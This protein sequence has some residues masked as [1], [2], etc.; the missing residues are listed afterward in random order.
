MSIDEFHSLESYCR[1]VVT[2]SDAA[3]N[4]AILKQAFDLWHET[5]GDSVD[6]WMSIMADTV[7]FRSLADGK[8]G[9]EFTA[10]RRSKAEVGEYMSGLLAMFEMISY[11]VDFYVAEGDRVIAIGSTSWRNRQTGEP[12]DT[13]KSDAVRFKDGKIIEFFEIYDTAVVMACAGGAAP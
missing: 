6:H 2:M 10:R 8:P 11:T 9:L 12:F 13:P 7:D 5:K 4:K 3:A 1:K